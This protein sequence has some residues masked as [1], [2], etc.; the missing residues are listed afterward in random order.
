MTGP[1]GKDDGHDRNAGLPGFLQDR[2][3]FRGQAQVLAVAHHL[4]IRPLADH[5][6]HRVG[7][8][9]AGAVG[10]VGDLGVRANGLAD[11]REDGRAA[12]RDL[13]R[14]CPAR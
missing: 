4:G 9:G 10:G 7:P 6:Q 1:A 14:S 8:R 12:V 3:V 13:R 11:G 5:D 2:Q